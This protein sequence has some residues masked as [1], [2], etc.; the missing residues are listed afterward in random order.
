M[1]TIRVLIADDHPLVRCGIRETLRGAEDIALV[2]EA[3]RGDEAQRLCQELLPDVLIL[4]LQMP[5]A[6]ATET[7][8]FVRAQC[9]QTRVIILTAYDDEVYIRRMLMGGV[10]G[11]VLKD[12]ISGA[13][14][15]AIR[16]V[17]QGGTWLSRTVS[18]MLVTGRPHI[19]T[20]EEAFSLTERERQLL[21]GIARG[22]RNGR[23]A[24]ELSLVETTVRHYVSDLYTKLGV[25]SRSEAII[26]AKERGFGIS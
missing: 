7:V 8:T 4:D 13:I 1:E 25:D 10:V 19:Q 6:T 18:D 5:G 15:T 2:G 14:I 20:K 11:Y 3:T 23:I 12:E 22:W 24:D 17:V 9:P 26:W 21:D 16:S